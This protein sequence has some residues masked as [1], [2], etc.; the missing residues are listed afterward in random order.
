MAFNMTLDQEE[1]EKAIDIHVRSLVPGLSPDTKIGI[2]LSATRGPRGFTAEIDLNP[3]ETTAVA[4]AAAS[5]PKAAPTPAVTE[6]KTEAASAADKPVKVK[7]TGTK[8]LGI[9]AKAAEAKAAQTT[10][11]VEENL[12]V[13]SELTREAD[14]IINDE[15]S[16]EEEAARAADA[17]D[18]NAPIAEEAAIEAAAEEEAIEERYDA[19]TEAE[20][21]EEAPA[22]RQSLFAKLDKPKN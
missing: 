15:P 2:S 17:I 7:T 9:A 10:E 5:A 21:T 20:V 12:K 4:T 8:P 3:T 11:T 16:T 13:A 18:L 6:T 19:P 1:I 22:P 14:A